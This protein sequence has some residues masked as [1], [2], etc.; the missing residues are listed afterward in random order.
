MP[1]GAHLF[2]SGFSHFCLLKM[3]LQQRGMKRGGTAGGVWAGTEA[4]NA[5]GWFGQW[6]RKF[7]CNHL[8]RQGNLLGT[9]T[10]GLGG[11]NGS[12]WWPRPGSGHDEGSARKCGFIRSA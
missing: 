9:D 3:I 10:S 12:I 2:Q 6:G 11:S 7:F 5:G 4:K 1:A 8:S